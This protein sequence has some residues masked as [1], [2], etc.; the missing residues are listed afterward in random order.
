MLYRAGTPF[1]RSGFFFLRYVLSRYFFAS[2]LIAVQGTLRVM[3]PCPSVV[4]RFAVCINELMSA[5]SNTPSC[6]SIA[7]RSPL[8]G[9]TTFVSEF[10]VVLL[11]TGRSLGRLL[12]G[13]LCE[14][15]LRHR[16]KNS[17]NCHFCVFLIAPP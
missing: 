3:C 11:G 10:I 17:H 15:F 8:L 13:Y 2:G 5:T 16:A 9:A 4:L 12:E 14:P 6:C 7:T 1:A